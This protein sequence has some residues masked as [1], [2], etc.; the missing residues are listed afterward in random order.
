MF[1]RKAIFRRKISYLNSLISFLK[2]FSFKLKYHSFGNVYRDKHSWLE[3]SSFFACFNSDLLH[4]VRIA[5]KVALIADF[6]DHHESL[7][8]DFLLIIFFRNVMQKLIKSASPLM[9]H[10]IRDVIRIFPICESPWTI[11]I[12]P[13]I[14]HI[15]TTILRQL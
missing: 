3:L 8:S 14:N 11:A 7:G 10:C 2:N 12:N 1:A 4:I 15:K 13:H 6:V 9:F 5:V